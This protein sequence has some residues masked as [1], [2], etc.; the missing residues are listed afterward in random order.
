MDRPWDAIGH[1]D[2]VEHLRQAIRSGKVSHSYIIS[3]APGAGKKFM[4]KAFAKALQCE[5]GG[6]DP[7]LSCES[8][9]RAAAGSHPDI[10]T[11]A[12]EK[13]GVITV[14]EVRSQ[15]V[16]DILVKPY[17][18]RR[19]VYIIPDCEFMNPQAQNALLKTIEEPPEY[20]TLILLTANVGA[21]LP[22]ILSRCV[23]LSLKVVED[24]L[25][26]EYLMDRLHIAD[27]EAEIDA[28]F[29]QGSLG[30]AKEAAT[31]KEFADRIEKAVRLL[32]GIDNMGAA[33]LF[34]KLQ[35]ISADKQGILEYM[36]IFQF[37]FR[38]VL[39][40]K[41]TRDASFLVFKQEILAIEEQAS[42][43]SYENLENILAALDQVR[44]RLR[45]NVNIEAALEPLFV[46]IRKK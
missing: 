38:D 19:K 45:A 43:R 31:S 14:D 20:A 35:E 22:T 7:C 1:E 42:E 41:A 28:S 32:K 13:P 17:M 46:T 40:F 16:S 2:V 27:Y 4:A 30:R 39:M 37:W 9:R 33:S 6:P 3:G 23:Q 44:G 34:E 12:H 25:V 29:A 15:V 26:K 5:K 10:I 21:I 18:G 24:R 11:V 8:C 36:D